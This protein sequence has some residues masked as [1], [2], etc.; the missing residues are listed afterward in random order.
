MASGSAGDVGARL[1]IQ[2]CLSA[3]L[4]VQP[5]TEEEDA[6]YVQVSS[7]LYYVILSSLLYG[8]TDQDLVIIFCHIVCTRN[9]SA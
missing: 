2:Q 4:M 3:R 9:K 5:A 8:K 7:L 6:K 1:V